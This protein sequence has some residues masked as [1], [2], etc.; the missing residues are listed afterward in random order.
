MRFIFFVDNGRF[1]NF[2]R[3]EI[4]KSMKWRKGGDI[5]L[6][7]VKVNEV[8]EAR[9]LAERNVD[10]TRIEQET[11]KMLRFKSAMVKLAEA[12][13][14]MATSCGIIFEAQHDIA[15]RMPDPSE[16][17][18]NMQYNGTPYTRER[19]EMARMRLSSLELC[20]NQ[21]N[22]ERRAQRRSDPGLRSQCQTIIDAPPPYCQFDPN[23]TPTFSRR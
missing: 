21:A 6:L 4:K 19:V 12:Y 17:L 20:A 23:Q 22:R 2:V 11:V 15:R 18:R 7:E 13:L 5:R 14:N 3:K 10:E 8:S 16:S 9:Q 1:L